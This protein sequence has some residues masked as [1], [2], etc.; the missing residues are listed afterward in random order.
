MCNTPVLEI[1]DFSK[2]FVLECDASGK[3]IGVT[4]LQEGHT[5]AFTTRHLCDRNLGK[6]TSDKKMMAISSKLG[7]PI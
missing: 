7:G 2:T 6:Y 1:L 3:G 5:L 4:L